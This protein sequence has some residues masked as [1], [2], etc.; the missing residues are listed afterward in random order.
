MS[1]S[2]AH[3]SLI[4]LLV[5]CLTSQL[6]ISDVSCQLS[7]KAMR[8]AI[9]QLYNRASS[10][11]RVIMPNGP[12]LARPVEGTFDAI[13][14]LVRLYSMRPRPLERPPRFLTGAA[15]FLTQMRPIPLFRPL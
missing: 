13:N 9:A 12:F 1:S 3:R 11:R 15:R 8:I 7:Q 2:G 6:L 4:L 14:A 5:M 10:F